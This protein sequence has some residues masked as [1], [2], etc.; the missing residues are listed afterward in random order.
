M[1]FRYQ[2]YKFIKF[3]HRFEINN[4]RQIQ[5]LIICFTFFVSLQFCRVH[6]ALHA[7]GFM[8]TNGRLYFFIR[9]R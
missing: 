7:H 4:F 5:Q 2:K 9:S 8:Y 1:Y 6:Y 3:Q